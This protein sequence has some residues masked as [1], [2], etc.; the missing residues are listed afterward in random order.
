MNRVCSIFSQLLQFFPSFRSLHKP[1]ARRVPRASCPRIHLLGANLWPCCFLPCWPT[2]ARCAGCGGLAACEGKLQHLGIPKAPNPKSTLAYAN[3]HRPWQ[4]YEKVFG[5]LYARC[6]QTA[7]LRHRFRF[8]QSPAKHRWHAHRSMREHV[9]LGA[10][11]AHQG[12]REVASG[13]GSRWPSAVLYAVITQEGKASEVKIARQWQFPPGTIRWSFLTGGYVDYQWYQRLTEQAVFFVT[14][15]RHDAHYRVLERRPDA[16]NIA[17]SARMKSSRWA[18]RTTGKRRAF[19]PPRSA[20][21]EE[22]QQILVLLTNHL[23]FRRTPP[24]RKSIE[25]AG[26][27]KSSSAI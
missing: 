24:S 11:P 4:L 18:V 5:V 17:T 23:D 8:S 25:T 26:R 3:E 6:Q 15:M 1:C 7:G 2:P 16:C 12:C 22:R 10:L 21:V 9:R 13:F 20:W 27:S 19:P 14:R